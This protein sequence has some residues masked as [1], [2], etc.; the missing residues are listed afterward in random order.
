MNIAQCLPI[1]DSLKFGDTF[2]GEDGND[3]GDVKQ[4]GDW[5]IWGDD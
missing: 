1:A 4:E 3:E 2:N 5:D